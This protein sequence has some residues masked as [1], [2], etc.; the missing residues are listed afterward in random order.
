MVEILGDGLIAGPP[1][2][3]DVRVGC[4][5][6]EQPGEHGDAV[7]GDGLAPVG[8]GLGQWC[9]DLAEDFAERSLAE[10]LVD[11]AFGLDLELGDVLPGQPELLPSLL[12][13]NYRAFG[14]RVTSDGGQRGAVSSTVPGEPTVRLLGERFFRLFRIDS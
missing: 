12:N 1:G 10:C 6:D 3:A 13:P 7:G 4:R 14:V 11:H 8:R 2:A 5:V 9:P